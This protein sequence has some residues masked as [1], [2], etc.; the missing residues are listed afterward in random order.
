M[1]KLSS[2]VCTAAA[3]I[4][5]LAT[6]ALPASAEILFRGVIK[7]TA[8]NAA[9]AG[10]PNAGNEE[11]AR[12]HPAI[13]PGNSNF[14]ALNRIWSYGATSYTLDTGS[15]TNAFQKVR[16]DSIG[17]SNYTPDKP[18]FVKM[19]QSPATITATTENVTLVGQIKNPWGDNGFENC[20]VDFRMVGIK[21]D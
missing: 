1:P 13:A 2:L 7:W 6:S 20:I 16:N 4:A 3:G 10:G 18:S 11:N 12:Y 15:F 9:C 17:W 14:S 8:A 21:G 19:T 5:L